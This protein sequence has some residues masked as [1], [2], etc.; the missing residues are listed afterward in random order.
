MDSSADF[1]ILKTI[2]SQVAWLPSSFTMGKTALDHLAFR[3]GYPTLQ[4]Y[5]DSHMLKLVFHWFAE[6]ALSLDLL[7]SIKVN[8]S[9]H[10]T[11]T[12]WHAFGAVYRRLG[13]SNGA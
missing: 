12:V 6:D 8:T 10:I 9:L 7:L 13:G 2:C 1:L 11:T 3:L 4:K 5:V